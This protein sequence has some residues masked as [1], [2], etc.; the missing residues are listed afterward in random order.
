MIKLKDIVEFIAEDAKI[1][2]AK[3]ALADFTDPNKPAKVIQTGN[4]L[5][6]LKGEALRLKS[7]NIDARVIALRAP[8]YKGDLI[9]RRRAAELVVVED[10]KKETDEKKKEYYL[11]KH[12]NLLKKKELKKIMQR[13][14]GVDLDVTEPVTDLDVYGDNRPDNTAKP[15]GDKDE[16]FF[17]S[18]TRAGRIMRGGVNKKTSLSKEDTDQDV[19][20]DKSIEASDENDEDEPDIKQDPR[21]KKLKKMGTYKNRTS[22]K[23]DN[24]AGGGEIPM[25]IGSGGP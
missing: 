15:T 21:V 9:D 18:D 24:I 6:V 12:P 23:F 1:S 13:E 14:D 25:G 16:V 20:F 11:L 2:N 4:A 19:V 5:N 22:G 17:K 8:V 10:D 3:Y 7:R